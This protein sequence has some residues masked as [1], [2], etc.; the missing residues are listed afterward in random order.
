MNRR[1]CPC[2]QEE[3][4]IRYFIKQVLFPKKSISFTE[5]EKGFTCRECNEPILSAE[6]KFK[7]DTF[8]I[9]ISMIPIAIFGLSDDISFSQ[10]FVFKF[11]SVFV[12]SFILFLLG[13]F[14][15]YYKV[16]FICNDKSS[17]EYNQQSIFG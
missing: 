8:T 14:R 15:Q 13:I 4:S 1:K 10:E 11:I 12:F 6:K 3:I 5:N 9:S 16:N 2:C 17:D 7:L